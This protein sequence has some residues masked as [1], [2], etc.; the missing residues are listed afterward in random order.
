MRITELASELAYRVPVLHDMSDGGL[1]VCLAEICV[2]S[3]VGARVELSAVTSL[4]AEDPHRL[5]VV[6][7]PGTAELPDDFSRR[8][9]VMGGDAIVFGDGTA[10]ELADVASAWREAIPSQLSQSTS[11]TGPDEST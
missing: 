11:S 8:V 10:V 4:F 5:L 1:A 3:G 2:A 6:M 9:G 7:E